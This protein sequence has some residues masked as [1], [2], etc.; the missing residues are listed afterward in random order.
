MVIGGYTFIKEDEDRRT[1]G[2]L[3]QEMLSI[4]PEV[5]YGSE[6]TNY[7]VAYGNIVGL[8]IESI[9]ELKSEVNTLKKYIHQSA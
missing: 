4:F 5:V 6:E 8:L 7:A 1:A 9:K 3:A 2:V